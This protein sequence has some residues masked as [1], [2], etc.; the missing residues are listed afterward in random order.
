MGE[1]S[2]VDLGN[3]KRLTVRK[4]KGARFLAAGSMASHLSPYTTRKTIRGY[5]RGVL[6][7]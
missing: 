4:F 3:K 5:Q 2:W 6:G 1:E 7:L